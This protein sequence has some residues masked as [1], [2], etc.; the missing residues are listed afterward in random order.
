MNVTQ[1]Y[2]DNGAGIPEVAD[3]IRSY[4][5]KDGSIVFTNIN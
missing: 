4:L 1:N 5:H 3:S 2:L